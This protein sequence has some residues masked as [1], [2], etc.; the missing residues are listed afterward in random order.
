MTATTCPSTGLAAGG[1]CTISVV[2]KPTSTGSK[3][4]TLAI[5][6]TAPGSTTVVVTSNVTL[7]GT[8]AQGTISVAG[9]LSITGQ[10]G[11][12]STGTLKLSNTGTAP[13]S[14]QGNP[15]YTFTAISANNPVPMYSASSST[16]N[17]VAPGKN[18]SVTVSFAVPAGTPAGTY[19]VQLSMASNASNNPTKVTVN[20]T[21][22]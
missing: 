8:G 19:S 7:S 18:C 15:V 4:A 6:G 3:P 14:L 20:G 5:T 11:R 9:T 2:F 17:N 10:A 21:V 22:K 13:F 16:C 1:T 12:T